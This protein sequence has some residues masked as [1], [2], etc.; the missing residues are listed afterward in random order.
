MPVARGTVD[1]K[2]DPNKLRAAREQ[3][4]W[5]QEHLATLCGVSARTIQ[6]I[7]RSGA[8][9][10]ESRSALAAVFEVP[11]SHFE[12]A[13]EAERQPVNANDALT[14]LLAQRPLPRAA[15]AVSMLFGVYGVLS[16]YFDGSLAPISTQA[17]VPGLCLLWWIVDE[18][19]RH[20]GFIHAL[21][22]W[23]ATL[24]R[25]RTQRR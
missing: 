3:R 11:L 6:R 7:E 24:K 13:L 16:A 9:S 8:V 5:S 14:H 20:D 18:A 1:L 17:L 10:A 2:I 12:P 15:V 4:G 23:R 21:G 25:W 19:I 22:H